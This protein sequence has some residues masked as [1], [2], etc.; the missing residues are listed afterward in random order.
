MNIL[1]KIV[2]TKKV[3]VASNKELYPTKLLEK[4]IYFDSPTLS[5]SQYVT[6]EDK[7]GVIAEFKK[8]SPSRP[9]INLFADVATVTMGYMQAGA[10]GLSVLTD[11][12]YFGGSSKDLTIARKY[13]FCPI[14]RKDF[15]IDEYH[16]I[17]AKSIGA[18]A[19]LLI[20]EILEKED[21]KRLSSFAKSLGLEVLLE[22][23]SEIQL[24][25]YHPNCELIGVN[26]R[27]LETFVTSLDFSRNLYEKLPS[28][29]VKVSESGLSNPLDVDNLR[30]LGYQGFLIGEQF[31]KDFDPGKA[32]MDFIS[33]FQ[34][35]Q[36]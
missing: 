22:L 16:I 10:S 30:S 9:N 18:D 34:N 33:S 31:M 13:N 15:I 19:I 6:R 17:E 21:V 32:A 5:L 35:K 4:S 12:D 36:S 2:A 25:K 7:S 26:N 8:K 23:H 29:A 1:E 11:K 28:E 3:E 20:C 27:N 24:D 14:L